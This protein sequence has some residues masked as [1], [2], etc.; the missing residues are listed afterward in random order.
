MPAFLLDGP[1]PHVI[2]YR[3]QDACWC[4]KQCATGQVLAISCAVSAG[5]PVPIVWA[6]VHQSLLHVP[7][8]NYPITVSGAGRSDMNGTYFSFENGASSDSSCARQLRCGAT[9]VFNSSENHWVLNHATD[10]PCY[11]FCPN[12]PHSNEAAPAQAQGSDAAQ[13]VRSSDNSSPKRFP[14]FS[15]GVW[16]AFPNCASLSLS[17]PKCRQLEIGLR[18]IASPASFDWGKLERT[19]RSFIDL[20]LSLFVAA[21]S[22]GSDAAL[23]EGDY[24]LLD[25]RLVQ[26]TGALHVL[27]SNDESQHQLLLVISSLQIERACL[28]VDGDALFEC[29]APVS[30][31]Q[32]FAPPTPLLLGDTSFSLDLFRSPFDAAAA[33]AFKLH[34]PRGAKLQNAS[35]KAV[36]QPRMMPMFT[37]PAS[38]NS[39][40]EMMAKPEF[41]AR[42]FWKHTLAQMSGHAEVAD[43][44]S[45][46]R[47]L[48]RFTHFSRALLF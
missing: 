9:L 46:H 13:V 33:P 40:K 7:S 29:A 44:N 34:L 48:V 43:S 32:E 10:G 19:S 24:K 15:D 14:N 41:D 23:F 16:K 45:L 25:W 22:A 18:P 21:A 8:L 37:D 2:E 35:K 5:F 31:S 1:D 17:V 39:V 42:T 30:Q 28:T 27:F 6:L 26:Q 38:I 4:I 12:L 3:D 20:P 47:V 11:Y 36:I